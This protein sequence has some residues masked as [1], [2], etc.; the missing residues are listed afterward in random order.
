MKGVGFFEGKGGVGKTS[1]SNAMGLQL[2]VVRG[3]ER[4]G[5]RIYFDLFVCVGPW[6]WVEG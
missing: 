6:V 1:T 2:D 3:R 5:F 4:S